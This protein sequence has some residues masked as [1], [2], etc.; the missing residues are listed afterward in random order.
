MD[1]I[2]QIENFI[3]YELPISVKSFLSAAAYTAL[4]SLKMLSA[5]NII[6]L[7]KFINI[8]R[9]S[10]RPDRFTEYRGQKEFSFLP[11]H[12]DILLN[13]P[14]MIENMKLRTQTDKVVL[15]IFE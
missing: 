11:G 13:L 8:N 1:E 7:E 6:K 5:D 12:R 14:T 9:D 3:G 10:V 4:L 15:I 2:I